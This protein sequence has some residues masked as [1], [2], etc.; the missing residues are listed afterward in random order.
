MSSKRKA[1]MLEHTEVKHGPAEASGRELAS[2]PAKPSLG[3]PKSESKK[4]KQSPVKSSP[5]A[6]SRKVSTPSSSSSVPYTP[7]DEPESVQEFFGRRNL[8]KVAGQDPDKYTP[9]RNMHHPAYGGDKYD[10]PEAERLGSP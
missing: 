2:P 7:S 8:R 3:K 1:S 5:P 4:A 10:G 9:M 6:S